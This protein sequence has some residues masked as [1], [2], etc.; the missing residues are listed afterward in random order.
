M[1]RWVEAIKSGDSKFAESHQCKKEMETGSHRRVKWILWIKRG[2]QS[3]DE[4]QGKGLPLGI[5][6]AW[7]CQ[8]GGSVKSGFHLGIVHV[9]RLA[10]EDMLCLYTKM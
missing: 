3:I 5:F 7:W 8:I 1:D 6:G 10:V 2:E 4:G 9:P